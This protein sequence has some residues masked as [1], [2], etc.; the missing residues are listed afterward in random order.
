MFAHIKAGQKGAR[1]STRIT[2]G[3][4]TDE[5]LLT[6]DIFETEREKR[7]KKDFGT[8]N[9]PGRD[10]PVYG[11]CDVLVVGG[12][13][14]GTAAAVAA[15]RAGADVMLLERYNHLGGL[16]TGGL[17]IW[18]D[19]MT[20]WEGRCVIRGFA[21]EVIDRLPRDA[22]AGPEREEWGSRDARARGPL[23]IVP[24]LTTASSWSPTVDRSG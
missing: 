7:E 23:V 22:V 13:P 17:V 12:G 19:R 18:I 3:K 16:S 24:R 10:L 8:W 5:R 2:L 4:R 21:E 9:E 6:S 20:D 1:M 14:S 11:R 15:A